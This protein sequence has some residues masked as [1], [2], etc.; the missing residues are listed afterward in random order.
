MTTKAEKPISVGKNSPDELEKKPSKFTIR[1]RDVVI[2]GA[3]FAFTIVVACCIVL[4]I[5]NNQ[6]QNA[7]EI[8][9]VVKMILNARPENKFEGKLEENPEDE[10]ERSKRAVHDFR[11][12]GQGN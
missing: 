9:R 4:R 10:R 2:L 1:C 5:D 7:M 11:V 12:Q 6:Q 8:E 3:S